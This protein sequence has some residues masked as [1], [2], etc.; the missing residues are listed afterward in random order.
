MNEE[1]YP[2]VLM[3][4]KAVIADSVVLLVFMIGVTFIF[5]KFENVNDNLRIAAFL[6]IF[7]FYDPIFTSLFGGTIGHKMNGICV[8]RGSNHERNVIFPLTLIRFITKAFL[9]WISLLTISG[10]EERKAIH[11]YLAGSVVLYEKKT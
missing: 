10:N 1:N 3:R 6:F 11:D 7:V 8:R 5:N 2:G 4:V 9:G